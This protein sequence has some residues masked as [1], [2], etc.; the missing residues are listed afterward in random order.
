MNAEGP[1]D[2]AGW[3]DFLVKE[4][5]SDFIRRGGT[6]VKFA[7]VPPAAAKPL[8]DG[9]TRAGEAE[10]YLVARVEAETTKIH[11]IDQLFF[12]VARQID[13]DGLAAVF[14]RDAYATIAFPAPD[15]GDL[16]VATVAQAHDVDERE[17]YRSLRRQLEAGL[18]RDFALAQEFRLAMLRLCS[19]QVV[20]SE[21]DDAERV[22][23]L[24]WLR[25]ELR[26]LSRLRSSLIFTRIGRHN[27]RHMLV[28][29]ARWLTRTG[30]AGL[31]LD[32]DIARL[33][34][35][36]RPP[37]EEREGLYYSKAGAMDA[38]EVLRQL[39]DSTDELSSCL[40]VVV[41]PPEFVLD[42]SRGLASYSALQL[43]I[44]DEVRDRHRPN[45]FAA[46]VRLGASRQASR[47]G[48]QG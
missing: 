11:L 6:A 4:Y 21:V 38:Y 7:V 35:A 17:L 15:E 45:P 8:H 37:A 42:E 47:V 9:L 12:A 32:L 27:A 5:L 24:E 3:L 1:L 20:A 16:R 28:S 43:R 23:V 26:Q 48:G 18:L 33:S 34:V 14:V 41:A 10:G 44:A 25:G 40:A 36:R 19:A 13:W 30:R 39:I 22:A 29:L 31:V 46:F 2:V